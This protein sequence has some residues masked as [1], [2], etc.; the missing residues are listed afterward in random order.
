MDFAD[1]RCKDVYNDVMVFQSDTD[2]GT[3]ML[4][5]ANLC[6]GLRF[7]PPPLSVIHSVAECSGAVFVTFGP[8]RKKIGRP[9][10]KFN[11]AIYAIPLPAMPDDVS[12]RQLPNR[13]P[14]TLPLVE[15]RLMY[16]TGNRGSGPRLV[17]PT[18]P[19]GSTVSSPYFHR[20][21][22]LSVWVVS[23]PAKKQA[24]QAEKEANEPVSDSADSESDN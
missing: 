9:N 11:Q 15:A 4:W 1:W 3:I 20:T 24:E 6:T 5:L 16:Q 19:I 22:D 21:E 8:A 17:G 2:P 7:T 10:A 12:T 14:D 18:Q 13:V 23:A